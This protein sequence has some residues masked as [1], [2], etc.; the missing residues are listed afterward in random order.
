MLTWF[1]DLYFVWVNYIP[2]PF[3]LNIFMLI[4]ILCSGKQLQ[5]IIVENT[6]YENI[7]HFYQKEIINNKV[8]LTCTIC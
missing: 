3:S 2:E 4:I 5:I 6:N 1:I 7:Q 8:Q